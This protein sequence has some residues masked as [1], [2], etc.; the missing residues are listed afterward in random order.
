MNKFTQERWKD[1]E[2]ELT[3]MAKDQEK[4]VEE[5]LNKIVSEERAHQ[6]IEKYGDE[7]NSR[8]ENFVMKTFGQHVR[9]GEQIAANLAHIT[10]LEPDVEHPVSIHHSVGLLLE[11]AGL[12]FQD[13]EN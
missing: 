10:E 8:L 1:F 11:L 4:I 6:I 13:I 3:A 12:E 2:K 7:M 5:E 9:V